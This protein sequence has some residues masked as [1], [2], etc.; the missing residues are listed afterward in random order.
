[1]MRV[2]GAMT[3]DALPPFRSAYL[4]GSDA[5]LALRPPARVVPSVA[6]EKHRHIKKLGGYSGPWRNDMTPYLVDVMD[7]CC[8]R[9]VSMVVFMAPSQVG[10]T[11][12]IL[13]LLGHTILY[14]P[15]DWLLIQPTK[16]LGKDFSGRRLDRMLEHSPDYGKE[17]GSQKTDDTT[18]E[19]TFKN[20]SIITIAW[21]TPAQLSS[22]PVMIVWIDERDRMNDDIGGEGDPVQLGI[23]RIKT[24][25]RNGLVGV[26]GSPSRDDGTGTVALY[27]AGSQEILSVVCKSCGERFTPG[28]DANRQPT[29]DHLVYLDDAKISIEE[30]A[31]S[32]VLVHNI[33]ACGGIH[34]HSDLSDLLRTSQ[35]EALQP[36]RKTRSFWLHG[37]L[38]R[39]TSWSDLAH[40]L[41][42]AEEHYDE[43]GD[44]TKLQAVYNTDFG[45]PYFSKNAGAARV[46]ATDLQARA[47]PYKMGLIPDGVRFLTA[48][49]DVGGDRFDVLIHGHGEKSESWIVDRFAIRTVPGTR[50]DL[51][52]AQYAEHWE[53]L[54]P[55]VFDRIVPF[56]SDPGFGLSPVLVAV[57]TGGQKGVTQNAKD[58][59]RY[60][61]GEGVPDRRIMMVKGA[62]A[63]NAPPVTS[64]TFERDTKGRALKDGLKFYVLGV[65]ELKQTIVN[66][67][68]RVLP[69]PGYIHTPIDMPDRYYKEMVAEQK[70]AGEWV[71]RGANETFDLMVYCAAG[72]LLIQPWH[73]DWNDTRRLPSWAE[74]ISL[75]DAA[76]DGPSLRSPDAPVDPVSED[77][78]PDPRASTPSNR[79]GGYLN[80]WRKLS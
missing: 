4:I 60:A 13:N 69:G 65:N 9:N 11:E 37:L 70:E 25:G 32:A 19:K 64:P 20:G 39:F 77:R 50:I 21:P 74:P 16:D 52:P 41:I 42:E 29:F 40:R 28:F 3:S 22:R 8:D 17:L 10:K 12:V 57:D 72:Y 78:S 49:V 73:V 1:M 62:A 23:N 59:Y 58:F 46:A 38:S 26:T 43:T 15:A 75:I 66:R 79:S 51:E 36:G 44:E 54:V 48:S 61:L 67:M 45:I 80:S 71:R 68:G 31:Q 27:K 30:R 53:V 55:E 18:F 24:Y 7:A 56:A 2:D 33:D 5:A 35:W 76:A 14:R 6:A 63:R 47:E 34:E